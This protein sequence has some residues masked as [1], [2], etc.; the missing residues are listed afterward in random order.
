VDE[1]RLAQV[2]AQLAARVRDD[3]PEANLRWLHGQ[4]PDPADREALNFVL[5]AAVPVHVPWLTLT[6]WTRLR[7]LRPCGTLA[8]LRRH[9]VHG[10][11]PCQLCKAVERERGRR[12]RGKTQEAA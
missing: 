9:Q 12:R 2:A 7:P 4:L 3:D 8:A 1:D 5:A 11:T 6:A 10:E